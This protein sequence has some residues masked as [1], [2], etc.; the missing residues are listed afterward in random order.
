MKSENLEG[1]NNMSELDK[2]I[3]GI[4]S[5]DFLTDHSN[6]NENTSAEGYLGI[7]PKGV[8]FNTGSGWDGAND[9]N[10]TGGFGW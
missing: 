6:V 10:T 2:L 5:G 1:G 7:N 4:F 3:N 8:D 9:K